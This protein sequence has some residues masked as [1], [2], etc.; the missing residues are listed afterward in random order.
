LK[1]RIVVININ[2]EAST[3]SGTRKLV[4]AFQRLCDATVVERHFQ[5][6]TVEKLSTLK[7]MA[8]IIGPQGVP[9]DAYPQKARQHLF[10]LIQQLSTPTLAV[11]GGHQA[12]VLAYG[13]SIAPVHGGKASKR[14]DG[15]PKERGYKTVTPAGLNKLITEP[16]QYFASHVEGVSKLPS[17][18]ELIGTGSTCA[19]QAIRLKDRPVYGVQFHPEKGGAGTAMLSRFLSVAGIFTARQTR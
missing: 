6:L 16:G 14:Y 4:R 12:L 18:F 9:F 1:A 19:V 15:M 3:R 17:V 11:C 2:P 7:P 10:N 5:Q 13:G 8:T